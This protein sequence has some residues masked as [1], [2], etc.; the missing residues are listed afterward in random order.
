VLGPA[1][2]PIE[3]VRGRI[4]WQILL[5]GRDV[6]PLRALARAARTAEAELRRGHVRL[7]VDVDPYSM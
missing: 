3:R 4:R 5:R 2:P 1:P 6:P 7:V